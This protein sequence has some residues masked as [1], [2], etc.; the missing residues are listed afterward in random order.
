[1]EAFSQF[2][3]ELLPL[4]K[5][6][7]EIDTNKK[8]KELELSRDRAKVLFKIIKGI[9][10]VNQ[11]TAIDIHLFV[12]K[13][14]FPDAYKA[15]LPCQFNHMYSTC[16]LY[17]FDPPKNG[18]NIMKHGIGFN[19]VVSYSKKFGTLLVPCPDEN[20]TE[21]HV[22]FSDLNLENGKYSLEIPTTNMDAE[23]EMYTLSIV[24]F[25]NQRFRFISS[26]AMSQQNCNRTMSQAFKNIYKN[27]PQKKKEFVQRCE[28]ILAQ[29]LFQSSL[30]SGS[31]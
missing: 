10:T 3:D 22:V 16:D 2:P 5:T 27:D 30:T 7:K 24:H 11:F 9:R 29:S 14:L 12:L 21:R 8:F 25:R 4:L 1:M 15:A 13:K 20:D 23:C 18:Q 31:T 6:L 19:E 26:R 17:E 28:E